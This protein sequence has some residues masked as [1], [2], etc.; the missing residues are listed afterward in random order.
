M[1]LQVKRA[2][3]DR[4]RV[5]MKMFT[6]LTQAHGGSSW[7][8][9]LPLHWLIG[10]VSQFVTKRSNRRRGMFLTPGRLIVFADRL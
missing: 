6:L 10:H 3:S 2:L 7:S 8:F 9:S 5:S 1:K 4:D